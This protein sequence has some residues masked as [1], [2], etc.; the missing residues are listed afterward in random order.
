KVADEVE[1][2]NR[3]VQLVE[4]PEKA[5]PMQKVVGAPVEKVAHHQEHRELG[6]Q[7]ELANQ[8]GG[9]SGCTQVAVPGYHPPA[10]E[11]AAYPPGDDAQHVP[12]EDQPEHVLGK[13]SPKGGLVFSPGEGALEAKAQ[14]R[15]QQQPEGVVADPKGEQS[16]QLHVG[17][18]ST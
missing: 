1:L 17:S 4:L 12:V 9:V 5:D 13:P 7:R 3:M 6:R 2:A 16:Q 10:G 18:K 8:R 11:P 15:D 14:R